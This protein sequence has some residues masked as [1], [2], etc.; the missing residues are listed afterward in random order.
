[1]QK[2]LFQPLIKNILKFLDLCLNLLNP[3]FQIKIR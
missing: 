2:L 3:K 1:L